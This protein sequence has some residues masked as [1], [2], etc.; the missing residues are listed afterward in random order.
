MALG[1][2]PNWTLA[3]P[4]GLDFE[5][6]HSFGYSILLTEWETNCHCS[7][8]RASVFAQSSLAPN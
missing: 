7:Q 5:A 2:V 3:P 1:E 4:I 6:R 8:C